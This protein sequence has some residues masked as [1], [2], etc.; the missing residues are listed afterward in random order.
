MKSIPL[1]QSVE[2][3]VALKMKAVDSLLEELIDPIADVG[4]PEKLLGKKYETWSPEDLALMTKVYGIK[5]PN[6]LSDLI[7]NKTYKQVKELE[8][9]E[10]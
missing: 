4:S 6:P 1:T 7:F 10:L 8:E 3:V 2:K 5:E 9:A